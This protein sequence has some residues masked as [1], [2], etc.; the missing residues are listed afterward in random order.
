[1]FLRIVGIVMVIFGVLLSG[2]VVGAMVLAGWLVGT[3]AGARWAF[4]WVPRAGLAELRVEKVEG[5]LLGPLSIEGLKLEV[6]GAQIELDRATLEWSPG[7]L[8]RREARV[9]NL[10]AGRLV[11][12]L[13]E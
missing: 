7:A 12:R 5:R 11:I 4:D 13:R 9:A 10:A 3:P 8:L 1:M 6:P 2:L